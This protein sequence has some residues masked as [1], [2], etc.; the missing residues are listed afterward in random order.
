MKSKVRIFAVLLAA[1]M[2]LLSLGPVTIM[3]DEGNPSITI[4]KYVPLDT[5]GNHGT[6]ETVDISQL[7]SYYRAVN[8]VEF[9][10]YKV[11][12]WKD[13]KVGAGYTALAALGMEVNSSSNPELVFA[14]AKT[15]LASSAIVMT[16][17]T[18]G[19]TTR[20]SL[21]L[22]LYVAKETNYQNATYVDDGE[23]VPI[24][25]AGDA[26]FI[27]LPMTRPDLESYNYD[28]QV[29]PKNAIAGVEKKPDPGNIVA[30]IGD[31][32]SYTIT[33]DVPA[34]V[35]DLTQFIVTDR[36]PAELDYVSFAV[37]SDEAF[38]S[39]LTDEA[40]DA[41]EP[42]S[43]TSG[44]ELKITFAEETNRPDLH[45]SVID[46]A[47][48]KIYIKVTATLNAAA[49][50]VNEVTNTAEVSFEPGNVL[51]NTEGKIYLAKV[52]I[53]KV[54]DKTPP[55]VLDGVRLQLY[56]KTGSTGTD[57]DWTKVPDPA[58][59]SDYIAETAG[60][61]KAS[62][63]GLGPGEYRIVEIKA[64]EGYQLLQEPVEFT[65]YNRINQNDENS[66][67]LD[68]IIELTIVNY[69]A[70]KLPIT[71]GSGVYLFPLI[72]ALLIIF[73]I[74]LYQLKRRGSETK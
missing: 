48:E 58:G 14:Q 61:G 52:E 9:T 55:N 17:A 66:E 60:G 22:G 51:V 42:T 28:V 33:V 69:E 37:A 38:S 67:V 57:A 15:N 29:Y 71:G 62:F 31:E 4:H 44:G 35:S 7:G 73:G 3:A 1:L 16:T 10:L 54:D 40:Y 13:G 43:G 59:G 49:V 56:E 47:N 12:D 46:L 30:G 5:T 65:V 50:T 19:S 41:L 8:G 70:F 74:G 18:D 27:T 24:T 53:T 26:F 25:K 64:A 36:L 32:V 20:D 45:Q 39:E 34:N 2:A 6:G 68:Q 21:A 23:K 11:A 63:G 72:G